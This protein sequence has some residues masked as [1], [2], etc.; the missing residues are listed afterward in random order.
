M[1]WCAR[2]NAPSR[3]ISHIW[4][5]AVVEPSVTDLV[6]PALALIRWKAATISPKPDVKAA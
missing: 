4:A 1:S 2:Q 6:P 3:G 5:K